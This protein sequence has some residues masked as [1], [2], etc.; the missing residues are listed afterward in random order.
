VTTGRTPAHWRRDRTSANLPRG[1]FAAVAAAATEQT[2][3]AGQP[4]VRP[5]RRQPFVVKRREP[6]RNHLRPEPGGG[7]GRST[8][9][10]AAPSVTEYAPARHPQPPARGQE[11]TLP[12]GMVAPVLARS[13]EP[14]GNRWRPKGR[15]GEW[16]GCPAARRA[17]MVQRLA[18]LGGRRRGERVERAGLALTNE[19]YPQYHFHTVTVFGRAGTRVQAVVYGCRRGN[20]Q[21]NRLA[22]D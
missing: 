7:Y 9:I 8:Q 12:V 5:R 3:R 21:R 10:A 13:W 15:N 20:R 16:N 14:A 1:V 11:Y 4:G 6:V 17:H 2:C 22:R 19:W 18:A